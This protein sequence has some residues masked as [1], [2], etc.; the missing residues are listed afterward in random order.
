MATPLF[1]TFKKSSADA[2]EQLIQLQ[3]T[4]WVFMGGGRPLHIKY[5]DGGQIS[6]EHVGFEGSPSDTFWSRYIEPFLEHLCISE[7]GVAVSMA[8]EKGVDARLLLPELQGLLSAGIT[9]VY[10]SMADVDRT[11]RGKGYPSSVPLRSV[12]ME[13]Q[14]MNTFLDER[15]KAEIAMWKPKNPIQGWYER[16]TGLAWIVGT[17]LT[18]FSLWAK[19]G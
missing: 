2:I 13:I 19:F 7:I 16:N 17:L 11:L 18:I 12:D 3:V 8:K 9:K 4:P 15:I 1:P 14:R 5:F 10:R 6:Y